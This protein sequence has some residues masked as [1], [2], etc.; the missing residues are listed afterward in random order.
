MTC[1]IVHIQYIWAIIVV[2][3]IT[4]VATTNRNVWELPE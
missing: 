3:I 4:E 2:I 1:P